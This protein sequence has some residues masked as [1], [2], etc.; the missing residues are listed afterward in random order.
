MSYI[1]LVIGFIFLI[2]GADLFVDGASSIAK[3]L[4][5]PSLIIGLTI[6]AFGTSAPEAAVSITGA[7]A[8]A[9]DITVGNVVGSNI[10]NLLVVVGV[11]AFI[12]PLNVK[13][14]IIAKE[15]PFA[16]L[17]AFVLIV[18]GLD[19]KYHNYTDNVLTRAD[20][21]M[22]LVLLGIFMYYLIELAL[23]A[24]K[25]GKDQE[26]EEEIKSYPLPKSILLSIIGIVGIVIGGDLVV[27]SA[28]N[29]ALAWG[30][31]QSLVGLTI[32]AVGTSLPELVT[33]IVAARK[34]ESDIALGNVI[35]SNIFNIFFVLGISSFIHEITINSAVFLDMFIMMAASFITYGFAASKRSINKKEGAFLVCLYVAYMIF[36]IWK[37]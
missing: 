20:G 32:V 33:S 9:N 12:S 30:M 7:F 29:I 26:D 17:G 18:L 23:T 14:S 24:R 36:V 37:G 13:K 8:G 11:A 27:D 25:E 34:G 35:G 21:I 19:S 1:L 16:L 28:S 31:S 5:I 6:V 10:F 3:T 22:L 2:K 15:F 4:K